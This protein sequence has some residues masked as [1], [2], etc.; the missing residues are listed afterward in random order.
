M[1]KTTQ[2]KLPFIAN[3]EGFWCWFEAKG[4]AGSQWPADATWWPQHGR[5]I[6]STTG[7][8]LHK[9]FGIMIGEW[10]KLR[11]I[12][13]HICSLNRLKSAVKDNTSIHTLWRN[14]RRDYNIDENSHQ[15]GNICVDICLQ[16]NQTRDRLAGIF[17]GQI[18]NSTPQN[19]WQ[20]VKGS[21][22]RSWW[23]G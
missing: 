19:E 1:C 3:P 13:W 18:P 23:S 7:H 12:K 17:S 22:C 11:R 5:T 16:K 10:G 6:A 21:R 4:P 14:K 8:K 20:G 9:V 2:K 15:S